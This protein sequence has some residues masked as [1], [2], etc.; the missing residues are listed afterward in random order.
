[1]VSKPPFLSSGI[2]PGGI[3][4]GRL[5]LEKPLAFLPDERLWLATDL[6]TSTQHALEL[7]PPRTPGAAE[8][9]RSQWEDLLTP[10]A[11]NLLGFYRVETGRSYVAA[12]CAYTPALELSASGPDPETLSELSTGVTWVRRLAVTVFSLQRAGLRAHGAIVPSRLA[13]GAGHQPI[14][15]GYPYAS[16]VDL[17]LEQNYLSPQRREDRPPEV[18]DDVFSL[19]AL[20]YY[21]FS[22]GQEPP[23]LGDD[24]STWRG[25]AQL[26]NER[27]LPP[28]DSAP[29]LDGLIQASL[30]ADAARRPPTVEHFLDEM[31]AGVRDFFPIER[32]PAPRA[33]RPPGSTRQPASRRQRLHQRPQDDAA[34]HDAAAVPPHAPLDIL[35]AIK[36]QQAELQGREE[37]V[38]RRDTALHDAVTALAQ[39]E[40]ALKIELARL[41][42][43][44]TDLAQA[45]A[46]LATATA[47]LRTERAQGE[48]KKNELERSLAE[49]RS[50]RDALQIEL[51]GLEQKREQLAEKARALSAEQ[52]RIT[53]EASRM[54]LLDR[55]LAALRLDLDLRT[56][57]LASVEQELT[58]L[59]GAA[60]RAQWAR[61]LQQLDAP[62]GLGESSPISTASAP[63]TALVSSTG[64]D[65]THLVSPSPNT[66]E[67]KVEPSPALILPVPPA[68][69]GAPAL[70]AAPGNESE[71]ANRDESA[72]GQS[73][74]I[75]GPAANKATLTMPNDRR[76]HVFAGRTLR[77]GRHGESDVLLVALL[78]G[79]SPSL[80]L[81]R[82]IS[83]KHFELRLDESAK[84]F[85]GWSDDGKASQH[86]VCVDGR[87]VPAEGAVLRPGS[88]LS[89]TTRSPSRTVPHWRAHFLSS[90]R[91]TPSAQPI[92]P[93]SALFLQRMDDAADDVLLLA[94]SALLDQVGAKGAV[95]KEAAIL[96]N[97][98]GFAWQSG[99]QV[100]PL[101]PGDSPFSAIAVLSL[102]WCSP[103]VAVAP[104]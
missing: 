2:K 71:A 22:G 7:L 50:G 26:R 63:G 88:L 18:C 12:V 96:R 54:E 45:K 76:L 33:K 102:G 73:T 75:S 29:A 80:L 14:L 57:Q 94:D 24:R 91:R 30:Q 15:T 83:R 41:K 68:V 11:P 103:T 77:F 99:E 6:Q 9:W 52:S 35:T 47:A 90:A 5:R 34:E 10:P 17:P 67:V 48:K 97:G 87:R 85:D 20:A 59:T 84:I 28:T 101:T 44:Q 3:L 66:E 16:C 64:S 61:F 82:E 43:A 38:R 60:D 62:T 39:K 65:A 72:R 21:V 58:R 8:T 25:L 95:P 93:L 69:D 42:L 79:Q 70:A 55:K 53:K 32:E 92:P 89:V 86:G 74:E 98:P 49:Q 31:E 56:Q 23:L 100:S 1:M 78:G 46:E 4:G 13:Q 81:N 27:R 40:N 19:A 104:A 51:A 36:A 37:E